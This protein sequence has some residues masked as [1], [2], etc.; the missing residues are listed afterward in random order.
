MANLLESSRS[1]IEN[2]INVLFYQYR[3]QFSRRKVIAFPAQHTALEKWLLYIDNQKSSAL[4][5]GFIED[6]QWP[7]QQENHIRNLKKLLTDCVGKSQVK[8]NNIA[9]QINS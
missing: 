7:L 9:A 3:I 8:V 6:G 2:L 1:L 5:N 4:Y